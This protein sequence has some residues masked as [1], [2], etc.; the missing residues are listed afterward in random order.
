M[1]DA[2]RTAIDRRLV[3]MQN[4]AE[5]EHPS[6]L[7]N[8]CAVRFNCGEMKIWVKRKPHCGEWRGGW[9]ELAREG[10]SSRVKNSSVGVGIWLMMRMLSRRTFRR[11]SAVVQSRDVEG[12]GDV[13]HGKAD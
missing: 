5:F 11:R 1:N 13:R 2:G 7:A 3:C 12:S 10:E 4:A 9:E 8:S 6:P